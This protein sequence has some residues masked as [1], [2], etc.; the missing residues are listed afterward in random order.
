MTNIFELLFI[1]SLPFSDALIDVTSCKCG[2]WGRVCG[3]IAVLSLEVVFIFAVSSIS[4]RV[5]C[6]AGRHNPLHPLGAL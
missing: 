3:E 6:A 2:L 1:F 4:E 5:A